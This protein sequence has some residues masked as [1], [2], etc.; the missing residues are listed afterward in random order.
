MVKLLPTELIGSYALPGWLSIA[1][2]R[3]A[4][5]GESDLSETLDD[6]VRLAIFDQQFVAAACRIKRG[7][8]TVYDHGPLFEVGRPDEEA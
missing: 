2:E 8:G 3:H 1:L 6:A 4:D 7:A 5:M